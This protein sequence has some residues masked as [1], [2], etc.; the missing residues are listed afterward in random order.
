MWFSCFRVLPGSAEAQ[1]IWGGI[2]KRLLIAYFIGNICQKI[3]KSIHMRQSYSKPKVG[4]F[5]ETRCIGTKVT[6]PATHRPKH[7]QQTTTAVSGYRLK[8][9]LFSE[10]Y[11]LRFAWVS[12]RRREMYCGHASLCVCLSACQSV[13]GRM[14]TLLHGPG[15]NLGEW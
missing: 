12:R 7:W 15:C 9:A 3:S 1:V 4:R 13:R 14:P 11:L 5:F 8:E 10:S 6:W 2:V